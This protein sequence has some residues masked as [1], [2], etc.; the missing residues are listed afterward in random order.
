[1]AGVTAAQIA[2]IS[3]AQFSGGGSLSAPNINGTG[4]GQAPE[5]S[6]ITNTS[7]LVPQEAQQVFV[8]ETDITNTQNKVAVIEEQATIK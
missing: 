2:K 7:T 1:M 3:Q 4:G 6:P 8:T 5:L